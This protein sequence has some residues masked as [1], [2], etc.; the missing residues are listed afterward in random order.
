[1]IQEHIFL[2]FYQNILNVSWMARRRL[3]FGIHKLKTKKLI[4]AEQP[5]RPMEL[6]DLWVIVAVNS[7]G[8]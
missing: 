5:R 4:Y 1:V 8:F 6:W 2:L 3:I 7:Q